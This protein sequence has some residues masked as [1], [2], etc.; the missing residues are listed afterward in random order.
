M[1]FTFNLMDSLSDTLQDFQ[2]SWIN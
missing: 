2:E 1:K